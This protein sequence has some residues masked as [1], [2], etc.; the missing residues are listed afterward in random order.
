M[1]RLDFLD[2]LHGH[3]WTT[4]SFIETGDT[5]VFKEV[6]QP[7]IFYMG[8]KAACTFIACLLFLRLCFLILTANWAEPTETTYS[9]LAFTTVAFFWL[10][11]LL[12][13]VATRGFKSEI[14]F[15]IA[16]NEFWICRRNKRERTRVT[17]RFRKSDI[18]T[19]QIKAI[20]NL[21][22]DACL[23]ARLKGQAFPRKILSGSA[24]DIKAAYTALSQFRCVKRKPDK[25]Y[26]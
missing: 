23:V 5:F 14:G 6:G 9:E 3:D 4:L 17:T 8:T 1:R 12:Y 16:T 21:N 13:A 19:F 26:K 10:L 2:N 25:V 18:S 7:S 24:D 15:D 11:L 20:D 22:V